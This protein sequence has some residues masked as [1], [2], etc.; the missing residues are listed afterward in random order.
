MRKYVL[1]GLYWRYI[2]PI[3]ECIH[4]AKLKRLYPD[5]EDDAY[6]ADELKYVWGVR[7][8]DDLSPGKDVNFYTM[9]DI[10]L[11]FDRKRGKYGLDIETAYNI[12]TNE[13]KCRYVRGLLERFT[14][15]MVANNLPT[16]QEYMLDFS[17]L[18]MK[19]EADTIEELYTRFKIV[20][21]GYVS[22]YEKAV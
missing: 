8:W 10:D 2:A 20:V 14:E 6:N 22:Q 11:Y 18:N 15:Y 21:D 13:G 19:F 16:D 3:F 12:R 9:N 5:Y 17:N 1:Y 4:K 7:S